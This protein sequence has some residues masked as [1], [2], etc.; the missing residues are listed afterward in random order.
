MRDLRLTIPQ[1]SALGRLAK[2][3]PDT[4]EARRALALLDLAR[5]EAVTAVAER[6]DVSRETVYQWAARLGHAGRPDVRLRDAARSGRPADARRA[7]EPLLRTALRTDPRRQGYRSPSW[8]ARLL[9]HH[10]QRQGVEASAA[11]IRRALRRLGY[12]WKRPRFVL[13]RRE[14]QWRQANGGYNAGCK[15]DDGRWCCSPT[16]TS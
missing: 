3:S 11:T 13:S 12:R 14:P 5:G 10:V 7:A 4:R 8:T 2:A 16:P 15:G 6:Y 1:R 9:Q